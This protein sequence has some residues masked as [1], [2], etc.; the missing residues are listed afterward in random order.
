MLSPEHQSARMSKINKWRL[1][2]VWLRPLYSCTHMATISVK[3]LI[4]PPVITS[5]WHSLPRG[6]RSLVQRCTVTEEHRRVSLNSAASTASNPRRTTSTLSHLS[7][8]L[9]TQI[10]PFISIV[11]L[12]CKSG[13][14]LANCL[15]RVTIFTKLQRSPD[16]VT[17][18]AWS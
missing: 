14:H 5:L 13:E 11:S 1:N 12:T 2:P 6:S 16:L 4:Q 8:V 18:W 3:G 15:R 17:F 9:H 7:L 10:I